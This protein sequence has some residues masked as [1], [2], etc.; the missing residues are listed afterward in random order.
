MT[1]HNIQATKDSYR[2]AIKS[3]CLLTFNGHIHFDP[4]QSFTV[5]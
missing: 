3:T 2:S 5:L 4:N 1:R